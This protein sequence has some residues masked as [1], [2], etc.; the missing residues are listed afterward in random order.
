MLPNY[1]QFIDRTLVS[2]SEVAQVCVD[3]LDIAYQ[4]FEDLPEGATLMVM[5][6]DVALA[7]LPEDREMV[8][9]IFP[10]EADEHAVDFNVLP[11]PDHTGGASTEGRGSPAASGDP[12]Q[13]VQ[14]RRTEPSIA[15]RVE[16]G[17]FFVGDEIRD[18]VG[19][20]EA[21]ARYGPYDVST[22]MIDPRVRRMKEIPDAL[23]DCVNSVAQ[24]LAHAYASSIVRYSRRRARSS[25]A[26]YELASWVATMV[27]EGNFV[28]YHMSLRQRSD[29]FTRE[30][31]MIVSSLD[32]LARF[33]ANFGH[34][35]DYRWEMG[36]FDEV[37]GVLDGFREF[38]C[39]I[40]P[41]VGSAVTMAVI[42]RRA[43]LSEAACREL[44]HSMSAGLTALDDGRDPWSI[45]DDF[46]A[47]DSLHRELLETPLLDPE[48]PSCVIPVFE[49]D[50][51]FHEHGEDSVPV[52]SFTRRLNTAQPVWTTSGG[53]EVG[54]HGGVFTCEGEWTDE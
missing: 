30:L 2:D 16:A 32:F 4:L 51:R 47:S 48:S 37:A 22:W 15:S 41:Y 49:A 43:A 33:T 26:S 34:D 35:F 31:P 7:S 52:G 10:G 54:L 36:D 46:R 25:Q 3:A 42:A 18:P 38:A 13:E 1:S 39:R 24:D 28:D 11:A 8:G 12:S 50:M 20:D 19:F 6:M 45:G 40:D 17:T 23:S 21:L 29:V 27:L 44:A 5:P 9:V 14:Q 53:C